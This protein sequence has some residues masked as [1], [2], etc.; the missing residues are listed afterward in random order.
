MTGVQMNHMPYPGTAPALNDLMGGYIQLMFSDLGPAL[1]LI[2]AGKIRPLAV[3]TKERFA[4][5]PAVPP[6]ADVGVPGFDAAAWQGFVAPGETPEPVLTKL[7]A[8]LNA[9]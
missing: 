5:L 8:T 6:L 9:I 3:T 1:P 4:P 7:N 2:N